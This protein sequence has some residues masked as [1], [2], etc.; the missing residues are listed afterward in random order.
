M[1]AFTLPIGTLPRLLLMWN[2]FAVGYILLTWLA[3][4]RAGSQ[5]LLTTAR[6]NRAKRWERVVLGGPQQLSQAAAVGAFGIAGFALPRA[7]DFGPP[8]LVIITGVFAIISSWFVLHIGFAMHYLTLYAEHDG[9]EFPGESGPVFSDLTYFAFSV[10]TSFGTTD[11]VV[12]NPRLRK[13]VQAH[14]L[15]SFF[16]NT[17]LLALTITVVTSYAA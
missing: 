4:A 5:G 15:L 2:V 12:T 16:F 13:A 9:L 11:V 3:F 17:I 10:G 6:A 1:C 7:A 8:Q 14:S